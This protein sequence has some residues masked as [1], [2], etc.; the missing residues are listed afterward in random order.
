MCF[1]HISSYPVM[2]YLL[3]LLFMVRVRRQKS[4]NVK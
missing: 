2:Q 4:T 1:E 3:Y